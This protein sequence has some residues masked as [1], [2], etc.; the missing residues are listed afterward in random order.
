MKN[1]QCLKTR[2]HS[3]NLVRGSKEIGKSGLGISYREV[4]DALLRRV[5]VFGE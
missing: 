1:H 3:I 2:K 5:V 4:D